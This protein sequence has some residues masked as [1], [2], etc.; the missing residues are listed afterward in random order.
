MEVMHDRKKREMFIPQQKYVEESADMFR[1]TQARPTNNPCDPSMKL[2]SVDSP[3]ANVEKQAM[4]RTLYRQLLGRLLFIVTTTRPDAAFLVSQ[5][6]RFADNPW[7][8]I[9][10]GADQSAKIPP[11]DEWFWITL[12]YWKTT[13]TTS[14]V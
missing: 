12:W 10:E 5:L 7:L 13:A 9:L 2:S 11:L 6:G 1:R 8:A 14:S 4:G 3:K